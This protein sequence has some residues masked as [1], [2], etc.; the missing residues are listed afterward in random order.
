MKH[1][2]LITV[3]ENVVENDHSIGEKAID[4]HFSSHDDLL[5][6]IDKLSQKKLFGENDCKMFAVGLKM[7]ASVMLDHRKHPLFAD[8]APHFGEFMKRLKS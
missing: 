8:F 7:F 6:I 4:I 2:Y 3:T 1:E 5:E